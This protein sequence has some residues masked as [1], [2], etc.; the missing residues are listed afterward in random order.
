MDSPTLAAERTKARTGHIELWCKWNGSHGS[1]LLSREQSEY[2]SRGDRRNH[3]LELRQ[4]E[5]PW[6]R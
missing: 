5:R 3:L 4:G 2:W 1:V 6:V